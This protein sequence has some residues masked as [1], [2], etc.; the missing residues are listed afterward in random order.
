M[1]PTD[2]STGKRSARV[3]LVGLQ[4]GESAPP[5]AVLAVSRDGKVIHSSKVNADG[6]FELPEAA[7]KSAHRILIGPAES[8][9]SGA[10][11]S[12]FALYRPAQFAELVT[13]GVLHVARPQW[14]LWRLYTTCVTGSVRL[15]R[16]PRWWFED[17]AVLSRSSALS[18]VSIARQLGR[19]PAARSIGELVAW[20]FRCSPICNGRVE[21]YRRTC[22]CVPWIIDDPRLDDLIHDLEIIVELPPIPWPP[23]P[24]PFPHGP[25]PDPGPLADRATA[26]FLRSGTLD[27]RAVFA[28]RDLQALRT[29]PKAEIAA[30]ISARHYLRCHPSCGAPVLVGDGDINPDGR[31]NICWFDWPRPVRPFCHDEYAYRVKQRFGPFWITVYDG[32]AANVWFAGDQDAA[33]VSHSPWAFSCREPGDVGTGAFVYLDIIGDTGSHE[34]ETPNAAGWDRVAAPGVTSGLVFP[35]AAS[36]L[37]RH[38]NWGGTLKL[39]YMFSEDLRLVGA[40]YYRVSIT[41]ADATGAPTGTRNNW[42]QG[43][44][45]KK[46]VVSGFSV[47]IVPVNLGPNPVGT[48]NAL[49]EIP[50]DT[51]LPAGE[52]WEAGQY[53]VHLDTSDVRWF[54]PA[55]RHLVTIEIFDAAGNRLRPNGTP[56]TGQPGVENQAAFTYRRKV[57]EIGPTLDV[58]FGALTHLFWWDNRPVY[59]TINQLMLSAAPFNGQC[60]FLEGTAAS[61]FGIMYQAYHDEPLFH[62]DHA[63][64]WKRGLGGDSG[65]IPVGPT[66]NV[67]V[68]SASG[69]ETFGT[70]L[71]NSS[72]PPDDFIKCAFTVFLHVNGK[73]TDGDDLGYPYDD[74]SAAFALEV[75]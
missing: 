34:L 25:G 32:V 71:H 21:V 31:F 4:A 39:N 49:Y 11:R 66:G 40:K 23:E 52:N 41:A 74:D 14:E 29:L 10:A 67:P 35:S 54:N 1:T 26:Q 24:G 38:R 44:S 64:S 7:L 2:P 72:P 50:Y 73:M 45:W 43:L 9:P 28:A 13:A 17:L 53:H 46:T 16:R 65:S 5:I 8:E 6:A 68:S 37:D 58:P 48:E 42:D 51:G 63:I 69:T 70:M 62:R 47:D 27:E 55:V 36:P 60:Q 3:T 61:T 75:K 57:A 18:R 59:A 33:L 20:P 30:Y 22:C 12:A 56:A 19:I 15:C